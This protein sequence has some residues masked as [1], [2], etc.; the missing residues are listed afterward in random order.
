M[1]LGRVDRGQMRAGEGAVLLELSIRQLRR[2]LA[3]YRETGAAA[4]VHGNRGRKPAHAL[5]EEVRGRVVELA[6][7][8]YA[9]LNHQHLSEELEGEGIVLSRASVRRIL[10]GAG[11][12]S[13]KTRRSPKHRSRR[14]RASQEGMLLQID[15][16]PHDWLEGRGPHLTLLAGIDDATGRVPYAI[17]R[18]TEDA[19]GYFL[20][21]RGIVGAYGRPLAVYHDR[22]EIF[23]HTS[24]A[25]LSLEEELAGKRGRPTQF[26]RL[27]EELGIGS[28]AAHSPQ[29][30]GRVERLF[31]TLQDRLVS[32]L[33]L[34][35]ASSLEEANRVLGSYLP[36][37][38]ERFGVSAEDEGCAY[39]P[40]DEGF[41]AEMVFSFKYG[42]K[43][44][45]D[46]AV[47]FFEHR[48]QLLP[49][50]DHRSYAG[51]AV[52]VQERMDGSIAVCYQGR[53][54][55]SKPAPAEAPV[56]RTRNRGHTA[57][58]G[59]GPQIGQEP[60]RAGSAV[61]VEAVD[62]RAGSAEAV[63]LSMARPAPNHPW[64]RY[65]NRPG[66]TQSQNP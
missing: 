19:Q 45:L 40:V 30:K 31:G 22:H 57:P 21:L 42:R 10:L 44:G 60:G 20:L 53:I 61:V 28:I 13:P 12:V 34:E 9:G 52:E 4:L 50:G 6:R 63:H 24:K 17:F 33:R 48:L 18:K 27:L 5:G 11:M 55:A 15:G 29:A 43:V 66:V 14:G 49:G 58:D 1:V 36:Q 47:R 54:L 64:R 39:R 46:N 51:R 38:N 41:T 26:G 8:R 37:F 3:A 59:S 25:Q 32:K 2:Q 35:G 56:L 7:G 62:K 16:S 23:R 65:P